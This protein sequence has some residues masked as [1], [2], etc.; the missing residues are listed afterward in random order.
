M[1]GSGGGG[2][3]GGVYIQLLLL[4]MSTNVN[5]KKKRDRWDTWRSATKGG[6]QAGVRNGSNCDVHV[7]IG[8]HPKGN[9]SLSPL[10]G[11]S[12]AAASDGFPPPLAP[13]V[14]FDIACRST[15]VTRYFPTS[16]VKPARDR[17]RGQIIARSFTL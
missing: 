17:R 5:L 11:R 2:G 13:A 4:E 1:V 15:R 6:R 7:L 14:S 9:I 16:E 3:G 8:L 10:T 12:L